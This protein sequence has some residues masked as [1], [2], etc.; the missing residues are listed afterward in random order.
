[1][2][3]IDKVISFVRVRAS[4]NCDYIECMERK[5][6]RI[7]CNFK[8]WSD[9][10]SSTRQRNAIVPVRREESTRNA[11]RL[12]CRCT[13]KKRREID[14]LCCCRWAHVDPKWATNHNNKTIVV[15][16]TIQQMHLS[17]Q[18]VGWALIW[19]SKKMLHIC[20]MTEEWCTHSHALY[21][22]EM[23][24]MRHYTD[25]IQCVW[26]QG[27]SHNSFKFKFIW[28]LKWILFSSYG[29]NSRKFHWTL[30]WVLFPFF[31]FGQPDICEVMV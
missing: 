5:K 28:Q 9:A 30:L 12:H 26:K 7:W 29:H 31:E 21:H 4:D 17:I 8:N 14:Y 1:M 20:W 18:A 10:T 27:T 24:Y 2:I 25:R 6:R 19:I 23:K 16:A 3:L 11:K 15:A 13:G 22:S